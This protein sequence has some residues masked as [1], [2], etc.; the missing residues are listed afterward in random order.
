MPDDVVTLKLGSRTLKISEPRQATRLENN[1]D[2]FGAG[3]WAF[4][5]PSARVLVSALGDVRSLDNWRILEL[6]AGL[7]APGVAA[8]M[9]GADVVVQDH[10]ESATQIA[11]RNFEINGVQAD[12]WTCSWDDLP[13]GEMF[14]GILAADVMYEPGMTGQLVRAVRRC[15]RPGGLFWL[16][17]PKRQDPVGVLGAAR[18]AGLHGDVVESVAG[19]ARGHGVNLYRLERRASQWM[20]GA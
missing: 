16:S 3:Y 12:A 9:L 20:S 1:M 14:D 17:D 13:A 10:S 5:S 11:L 4:V 2:E 19:E 6:G 18:L 7:G 8:A 15:L